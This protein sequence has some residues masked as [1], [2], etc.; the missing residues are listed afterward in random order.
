MD[1]FYGHSVYNNFITV[2][3]YMCSYDKLRN[4]SQS[5]LNSNVLSCFF[6]CERGCVCVD[7]LGC[8]IVP[9]RNFKTSHYP[10]YPLPCEF[11][12]DALSDISHLKHSL[13]GSFKILDSAVKVVMNTTH[14]TVPFVFFSISTPG[15]S[16]LSPNMAYGSTVVT[17]LCKE[18]KTF[19]ITIAVKTT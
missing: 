8:V 13:L 9:V 18:I 6:L 1:S 14:V 3:W 2:E 17:F 7:V 4:L 16:A 10:H 12:N 11:R 15:S 19:V 5:S